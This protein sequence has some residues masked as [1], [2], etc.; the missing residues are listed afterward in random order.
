MRPKTAGGRSKI[1]VIPVIFARYWAGLKWESIKTSGSRGL[2]VVKRDT[3]N[4]IFIIAEAGVNHN[5]SLEMARQLVAVAA[6][7]RGRCGQIPNL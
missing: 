3:M 5:G 6:A 1:A 2:Q 7:V 4:Q